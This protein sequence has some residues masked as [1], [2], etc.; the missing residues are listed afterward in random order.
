M[1]IS[2]SKFTVSLLNAMDHVRGGLEEAL[3]Y[4]LVSTFQSDSFKTNKQKTDL[5]LK[6]PLCL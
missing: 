6:R 2:L 5:Y 4:I 1:V 3:W